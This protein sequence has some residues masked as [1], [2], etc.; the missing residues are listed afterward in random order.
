[1]KT[2]YFKVFDY[3]YTKRLELFQSFFYELYKNFEGKQEELFKTWFENYTIKKALGYFPIEDVLKY[4][5]QYALGKRNLILS[6]VKTYWSFC[7]RPALYPGKIKESMNFFGIESLTE[8]EVKKAYRRLVKENHPDRLGDKS[9][10]HKR[11][12]L[13]NYHYQVLIGYIRRVSHA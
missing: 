1:M 2:F 3:I 11:M 13:I 9:L 5:P 8:K 4:Y 10:A 7:Q 12:L 6:Y